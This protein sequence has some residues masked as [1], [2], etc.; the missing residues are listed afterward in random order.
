MAESWLRKALPAQQ[1]A[2]T[3]TL[4]MEVIVGNLDSRLRLA[5][6]G[7]VEPYLPVGMRLWGKT[8]GFRG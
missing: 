8:L 4:R 6:C 3:A 2:E 1:G 5:P 7:N